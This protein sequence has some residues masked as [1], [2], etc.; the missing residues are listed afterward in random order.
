MVF[1]DVAQVG[2]KSNHLS[3]PLDATVFCGIYRDVVV[4]AACRGDLL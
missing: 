4:V 2:A 1:C 3:A